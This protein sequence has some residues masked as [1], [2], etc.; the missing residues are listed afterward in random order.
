MKARKLLPDDAHALIA[1]RAEALA[2][3]PLSFAASLGDDVASSAD[4]VRRFLTQAESQAVFGWFEGSTLIGMVGLVRGT[5]EK[6]RHRA[7]VWGM[8]VRPNARR[9]GVGRALLGA[10]IEQG[11]EWGVDQLLI[12]VQTCAFSEASL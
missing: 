3:E 12:G 10:V 2:I 9:M 1:L 4:A 7:S 11:R 6:Q 8:Y 5:K